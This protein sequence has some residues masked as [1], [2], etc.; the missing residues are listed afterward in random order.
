MK[1]IAILCAG[2]DKINRGYETHVRLF[3]NSL[4]AENL[5]GYKFTL[6]KNN[7]E[8]KFNEIALHS[9]FRYGKICKTLGKFRGSHLYWESLLFV[10]YFLVY[11]NIKRKK[12]DI[13]WCIEPVV[14]KMLFKFK[15]YLPGNPSI[16]F[17][18]G[19]TNPPETHYNISDKIHQVNIENYEACDKFMKVNNMS[20]S[21]T[22]IPHFLQESQEIYSCADVKRKYNIVTSKVLLSVGAIENT[23]KRMGYII[24]EFE[25]I[26][27]SWTLLIAGVV[28]DKELYEMAKNRYGDRFVNIQVEN[29]EMNSLY[30]LADLVVAA[31]LN[32][33]FGMSI[34]E[35]M[36]NSTPIV[37]HNRKLFE[38]ILKDSEYLIDMEKKGTLSSFINDRSI[39]DFSLKGIYLKKI[40][41][42]NYT[43]NAVKKKYINLL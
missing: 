2:L 7:G 1:N 42:S 33:G 13:I 32:E 14:S 38:W 31:S 30:Q 23:Q 3:F 8:E 36:S 10:L 41:K 16:I 19:V 20:K 12:Y 4:T 27:T 21:H 35:A 18:H 17:T 37:L 29:S 43:W 15:S 40:F 24:D 39:E 9:P 25:E 26:D 28:A 11:S 34:I 22:L 6:Y 5:Q